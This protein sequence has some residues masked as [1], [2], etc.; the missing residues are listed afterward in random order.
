M[1]SLLPALLLLTVLGC[2][3]ERKS[4][5]TMTIT[6][7]LDQKVFDA[8]TRGVGTSD[9]ENSILVHFKTLNTDGTGEK[10]IAAQ[11]AWAANVILSGCNRDNLY[12]K[13]FE[14]E[15]KWGENRIEVPVYCRNL[16]LFISGK[17]KGGS[18]QRMIGEI[19]LAPEQT[20]SAFE[21][22]IKKVD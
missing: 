8:M 4:I 9:S 5:G 3:D 10:T 6:V 19:S 20:K 15:L 16:V 14:V 21:L 2:S 13:S 18:I 7:N 1:K 17:G 22:S 11:W 12:D